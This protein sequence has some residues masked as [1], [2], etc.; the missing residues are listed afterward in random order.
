MNPLIV[1]FFYVCVVDDESFKKIY[2]DFW[3]RGVFSPLFAAFSKKK[4]KGSVLAANA[5][6]HV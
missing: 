3:K 5:D 2:I 4:K 1:F 6:A